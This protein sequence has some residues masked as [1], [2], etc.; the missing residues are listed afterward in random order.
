MPI[1][2]AAN[3][4]LLVWPDANLECD[5]DSANATGG[6]LAALACGEHRVLLAWLSKRQTS[7]PISPAESAPIYL[8]P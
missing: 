8:K 2:D 3:A 6:L 5:K 7:R 4:C 1:G